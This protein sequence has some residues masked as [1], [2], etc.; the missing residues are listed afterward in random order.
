MALKC[1]LHFWWQKVPSAS[2]Y[3]LREVSRT[4]IG[5]FHRIESRMAPP[6]PM[7]LVLLFSGNG[8]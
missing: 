4:A 5:S 2:P 6:R 7:R 3:I 8:K 1:Y